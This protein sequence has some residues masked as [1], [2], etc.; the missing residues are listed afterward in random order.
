MAWIRWLSP[1]P[2]CPTQTRFCRRPMNS[3]PAKVSIRTRSMTSALNCQSKS[4]KVLFWANPA[5][6]MRWARLRSRRAL[7]C[8]LIKARKNSRC[9]IPSL[10][11]RPNTASSCSAK[12]GMRI[13]WKSSRTCRRSSVA[14]GVAG[15]GV[16]FLF[17]VWLRLAEALVARRRP[18]GHQVLTQPGRDLPPFFFGQRLQDGSGTGLSRE[19]AFHGRVGIRAVP[20]G[21][22]Q[23]R[24]QVRLGVCPQ[25]GQ[26]PLRLVLA[27]TLRLQQ[28]LQEPTARLAQLGEPFL[29]LRLPP[30]RVLDGPV[31]L[32][33]DPLSR[34]R[35]RQ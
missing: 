27:V 9:D 14:T 13:A 18:G 28:A 5:A 15:R 35:A 10:S 33:H 3:P 31:L 6:R 23:R 24:D 8:S 21:P 1:T 11:A 26:H 7:A 19:D 4:A 20:Y 17:I 34:D 30:A 12:R 2:L 16:R 25:Q 22:L 32:V 29:Q